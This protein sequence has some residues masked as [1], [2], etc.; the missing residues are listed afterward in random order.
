M[1]QTLKD[2]RELAEAGDVRIS[3]HGYNELANDGILATEVVAGLPSAT[4][5]EDYP[6]FPKGRCVLVLEN[7]ASG[8]PIHAV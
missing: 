7:D 5:V 8:K 3:A 4:V 6:D 1:S 2:I